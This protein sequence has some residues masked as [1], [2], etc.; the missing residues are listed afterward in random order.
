[1]LT[2]STIMDPTGGKFGGPIVEP[3]EVLT[4]GDIHTP[5]EDIQIPMEDIQIPILT[6][7]DNILVRFTVGMVIFG[8]KAV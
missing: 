4:M 8:A 1:M 6:A 3:I 7:S 5:T 2:P